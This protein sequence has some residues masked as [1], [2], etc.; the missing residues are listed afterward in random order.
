M[1][2]TLVR[3]AAQARELVAYNRAVFDRFLR[4]IA[5]LPGRAAFS[6]REIGH[7][8]LFG[9]LVHVLNVHEAWLVY[10]VPGRTRELT[11]RFTEPDRH[12]SDWPGLRAYSRQ[13]WEGIDGTV[14][15]LADADFGRTVR[16]PWMPGLYTVGD[17]FLQTTMEEAHHI[18]E[19]IGAL[20]QDDV[21]STRMTWIELNRGTG[22][23]RR[24]PG[25]GRVSSPPRGR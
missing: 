16:A 4:R 1:P 6:E 17:A 25:A 19:V 7:H 10:I 22:P 12:P 9:T 11:R 3:S 8:S 14:R 18:G 23:R 15:T 2:T 13:V 5:R 21:A 20:W 24:S